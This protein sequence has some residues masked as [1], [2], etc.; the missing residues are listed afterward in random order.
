[1]PEPRVWRCRDRVLDL[2]RPVLMGI[3]NVTPDSFSDG[4]RFGTTDAAVAAA[5]TMIEQG[6]ALVDVG[7][8]STRPG[9]DPVFADQEWARVG[10]VIERLAARGVLLSVDTMKAGVARRALD[11]GAQVVNDVSALLHDPAMAP[12]AAGAGAGVVLMHRQGDSRTMQLDPHYDDVVREVAEALA[13]RVA[14]ARAAGIAADRLVIDPGIGFGKTAA[15]NLQLLA[16]LDRFAALGP[17]LLVG[18]SRKR[19]IGM[20]TGAEVHERLPGSLAGLLAAVRRG[21]LVL[22]VHD[23]AASRQALDLALAIEAERREDA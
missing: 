14:A 17:P 23:V 7:G 18:L 12:L 1:M 6:A 3:L 19:F 2:S 15:H 11:A 4:G 22:R 5:E 13:T 10:P 9:A 8:E 20:V 16:N 21:A